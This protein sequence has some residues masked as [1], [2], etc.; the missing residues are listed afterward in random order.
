ML[1]QWRVITDYTALGT[2]AGGPLSSVGQGIPQL[3]KNAWIAVLRPCG[4]IDQAYP[5]RFAPPGEE[6]VDFPFF[7]RESIPP[8][9]NR[10]KKRPYTIYL[11]ECMPNTIFD[12]ASVDPSLLN[13]NNP[14]DFPANNW[15]RRRVDARRRAMR[16]DLDPLFQPTLNATTYEGTLCQMLSEIQRHLLEPTIDGGR[17]WQLWTANEVLESVKRRLANFMEASGLIRTRTNLTL[18]ANSSSTD[19]PPRTLQVRKVT[20]ISTGKGNQI[21]PTDEWALQHGFPGWETTTGDPFLYIEE[22]PLL[23][24]FYPIP[25]TART[26]EVITVELPDGISG[27]VNMPI[28]TIFLPFIKWGVI[29][30]LLRKEGEANDPERAVYAEGRYA[31][32][33][34]LAR[35]LLGTEV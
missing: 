29:A 10:R 13:F 7:T 9:A 15:R 11:A 32:G 22:V 27:C 31:E 18:A 2:P 16:A 6:G 34:E 33:I 21:T 17:T 25:T 28:P 26:I 20:D 24:T 35:L 4:E 23:L 30:D 5:T 12:T 14:C 1:R 3:W 8:R 19:L